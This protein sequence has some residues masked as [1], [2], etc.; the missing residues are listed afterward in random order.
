MHI[1]RTWTKVSADGKFSDGRTLPV[2]VWGWGEDESG[3]KRSAA[4]RLQRLLER[5][6]RGEPFPDKYGYG[7]RPLRE[8]ILQTFES[9][10]PNEP[11]A[12]LTRNSYGAQVLNA[13]RLLFLDIDIGAPSLAQRVLRIFGGVSPEETVLTKLRNT[14]QAYG[15]ATFRVYRTAAGFRV[16]GIGRDFD[17]AGR[18]VQELMQATGTDPAFARLCLAQRSFRARLTP[19]PWRCNSSLPP[20]QHPRLNGEMQQRFATRLSGYE[21][22]S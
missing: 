17:P 3:S 7:S 6:R 1:P 8:E 16:M 11:S 12:I 22:E 9:A 5:I 14:L 20:G 2:S 18:E 21:K 13:A 10:T 4:D 19:K 15:R